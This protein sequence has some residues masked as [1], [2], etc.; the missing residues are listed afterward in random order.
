MALVVKLGD[1]PEAEKYD[2][3]ALTLP[4]HPRLSE[5]QEDRVAAALAAALQ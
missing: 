2:V 3:R 4:L 5:E 1:F